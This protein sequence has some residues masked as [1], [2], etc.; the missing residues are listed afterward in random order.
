[1]LRQPEALRGDQARKAGVIDSMRGVGSTLHNERTI[2]Q[3]LDRSP[4]ARTQS[5]LAM[6]P[7]F[8]LNDPAY[9]APDFDQL[10][11]VAADR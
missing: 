10:R 1:M 4:N 5:H 6:A 2:G 7:K 8:A 11:A 3:Y 9:V